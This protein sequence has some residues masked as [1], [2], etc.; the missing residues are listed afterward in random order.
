MQIAVANS[1]KDKVWKNI[2]ISWN[3]FLTKASSTHRT[4]ESAIEYKKLPKPKQDNVK[5][6]GG[7]VGGRLKNG[8]RK[9]GFVEYRSMLTLDMDYAAKDIWGQITIFYDFTCCIYSTHKH[10]SEKPRLRLIIPLSRNVTADEYTAVGRMVASDIGIEQF[11]DTTYEPT[12][13]MYWPST[14]SDGEFVF[15]KQNGSLLD[16]NKVLS[17]YK[18]WHDSSQ[19]PVS[20]R[21]TNIVKHSISKQAD[22]LEKD[23]LIGVFCRTYTIEDAI[24]K[25]LPDVYKPSLLEGRYD[26]IPADST[27]GVLIYDDKFA[28]SHHATD[29][30]SSKLC[31]AFDLVRIHKFGE[32]DNKA[33]GDTLTS[34]LPSFKAM[35]ELCTTDEKVKKHLAQERIEQASSEFTILDE[36]WQEKLTINKNGQIRDDLQNLVLIMQNDENLKSIA[37]NQ[38]RDGIE[39]K[40]SL[41]WKQIK[42]GWNDSDM[43]ALKVYFDKVYGVWSPTK[44]KEALIAVAAERAYHP[45][46][47]YL[48]GLPEW[49]KLERLDKLLIDYLGAE[50]NE[51]SRA[52]IRKTLVAAVARIYE[53]G[54]KFDSVLIL[55]G[56][57]GIGKSTFFSRLGTKWFS[58]SL[59][60]TDMRD[61]AAAEKLQGYW[62]L[63]LG[64]LAGIKK[65]DVETVKS[66]VS[67]TDDKY[68]ASYGVNVESH[69]R[70]CVIVGSTNSESGFLRDI[71]GN[72]RF[73]PVR[74]SGSSTK[75]AWDLKDIDQIWVEALYI[76][77]KGEDLFLKGNEAQIAVSQQAEAMETDDREG[78]VREY[79]E[80]LL[81]KNWNTIALYER[82]NF[83]GGGDFGTAEVG[84]E[85]R[86]LVCPMEIWC[87]C[88]GR[89]SASLKKS[90]S[91]EITSILARI[92]NWKPYD[93][94]KSGT[95][96]FPIYNKQRAFMRVE[97]E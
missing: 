34:K 54:T 36:N 39:A 71:T 6:V 16:P 53:P 63:E 1:R 30:A 22:P 7:F 31:N 47:E 82:R 83:L 21:Q 15:E 94:T 58:D 35:Q 4:A 91:Y 32:F 20:S 74:V 42:S 43:S 97:K 75:K 10:T 3:E 33:D 61:K 13:L 52:V 62:L 92:E 79:L 93:G 80:K 9:T 37:Y 60:I 55:N 85:K 64:E 70:Q 50:D 78:L 14:S 17:R 76:Y 51:Y 67:R 96:R 27:A 12:R 90:D 44:L 86:K 46:K 48:N 23:G 87:E 57:Q 77:R 84:T 89:D 95:T 56:P 59:T 40:G 65:T 73:W 68:R 25:F 72:R 26:Y 38:H 66:F 28:F 19:W 81:P 41:P 11:D 24:D 45:I 29:P 8:K 2:E 49:D 88:F 69:P 5:D 18:D